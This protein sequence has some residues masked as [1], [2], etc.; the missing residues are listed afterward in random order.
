[1]FEAYFVHDRNI[2]SADV[3]AGI[4]AELGLDGDDLRAALSEGRHRAEV[5]AEY[6]EARAVGV[7]AVP[8][9]VAGGYALVG[10]HPLESLRKL[11][12]HVGATPRSPVAEGE[13][14]RFRSKENLLGPQLRPP[15]G[16]G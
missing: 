2:A 1:V 7:T 6:E 15:G 14:P 16:D 3:L 11:L 8:T 12:S 13:D 9:F 10:A 4:A 5:E